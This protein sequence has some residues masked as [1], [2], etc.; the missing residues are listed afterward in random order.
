[1]KKYLAL[2]VMLVLGLTGCA[3]LLHHEDGEPA[4]RINVAEWPTPIPTPTR[5]LPTPF[6]TPVAR[7][8]QP[9][10]EPTAEPVPTNV[11]QVEPPAA[12]AEETVPVVSDDT[13]APEISAPAPGGGAS[14]LPA[15]MQQ[16]ALLQNLQAVAGGFITSAGA[17]LYQA[18]GIN[19]ISDIRPGDLVGVLA[20][21]ASQT[22][23]YVIDLSNNVG[24]VL[25]DRIRAVGNIDA[26][27]ILPIDG[28]A[29]SQAI[30]AERAATTNQLPSAIEAVNQVA[31]AQ[32]IVNNTSDVYVRPGPSEDFAPIDFLAN[33]DE[34]LA[35]FGVDPTREWAFVVPQLEAERGW[36]KREELR[37]DS[38]LTDAPII[39]TARVESNYTQVL[40]EP[41]VYGAEVAKL[42]INTVVAVLGLDAERSWAMIVPFNKVF[43]GWVQVR[44]L[45]INAPV[46]AIPAAPA[47]PLFPPSAAEPPSVPVET[48]GAD[49]MVLQR[50]SGGEIAVINPDGTGFRTL[51]T[52]I[53]PVLSPDRSQIAFTRWEGGEAGQG[54]LWAI[55]VDGTNERQVLGFISKQPKGPT[56]SPDG[57]HIM[58]NFQ[59]GGQLQEEEVCEDL[60][61][62]PRPP[63]NADGIAVEENEDGRFF[64]CYDTPPNP[65]WQLKRVNVADGSF[66]DYD[67]GTYAFRPTWDPNQPWRVISDGGAGL[68]QVDLNTSVEQRIT[69]DFKDSSPVFS[70]DG[71]FIALVHGHHSGGGGTD[72]HRLNSN[73]SG[74]IRLTQTPLWITVGPDEAPAWNNVAPAWSP[75]GTQI[76]FLTDR[77]G[78][79]EVWVMNVDGSD[80]RPL[81][82]EEVQAQL[83]MEYNFVDER[84]ISWR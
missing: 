71:R 36:I 42:G 50:S 4:E 19:P 45:D 52:G 21:D 47:I 18:P 6:P 53:D 55:N 69:E 41:G 3:E 70:P 30:A 10:A 15:S 72:I 28:G 35:V 51:T 37:V 73:G 43:A 82:S 1:M 57:S 12:P 79:W 78:Q 76:A 74:R 66:E 22:W 14:V 8:V 25:A 29:A 65:F 31:T 39:Y 7:D 67:G 44:L 64:L 61:N 20:K 63:R 68:V 23:L 60:A 75:D 11:A 59:Q 2:M 83:G 17:T 56:W 34:P 46:T 80:Q 38:S 77:T 32:R 5:S 27:T 33:P 84:S 26:A 81:F 54:S 49:L 40:N 24:W 58:I 48:D 62:S 13:A 16:A 9:T